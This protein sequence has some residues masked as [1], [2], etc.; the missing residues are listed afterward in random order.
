[1]LIRL[2]D[3]AWKGL[4]YAVF[5]VT[6][7]TFLA[8]RGS[9]YARYFGCDNPALLVL[10]NL[11]NPSRFASKLAYG[12]VALLPDSLRKGE[13]PP[14]RE[15]DPQVL[16]QAR[17]LGE[18]GVVV[19]E[20][21]RPDMADHILASYAEFVGSVQPAQRYYNLVLRDI[22]QAILEFI[23]DPRLLRVM[24]AHYNGRQP[25]LRAAATLKSTW[26]AAD[27]D[28]TRKAAGARSELNV[29]WH[30]DTVNMVQI[31]FLLNDLTA[32]DTHM[33]YVTG[34]AR[35]HRVP[36]T[37]EDYAYS[38]EYIAR[39]YQ[40]VPFVGRKGTILLWDS[41]APHAA[42]VRK[43]RR[44][45]FLQLLYSPGNNI[46]ALDPRFGKNWGIAPEGLDLAR[47]PEISR[48]CVRHVM[49]DRPLAQRDLDASPNRDG[50]DYT[51]KHQPQFEVSNF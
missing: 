48:R 39:H 32:E 17:E 30:Y 42:I 4:R 23:T 8:D 37:P 40:T 5:L 3:K 2:L 27:R 33:A 51:R 35:T 20:G 25:Y 10:K 26:P 7:A 34:Q 11:V 1:V 13:P 9:F 45:D 47:L 21:A 44:R 24:A 41:N 36:L 28:G 14:E 46:L 12:T 38:D 50:I 6:R 15:T 22:D 31:H 18:R 49:D 16:A 43:G 29:D 19:L